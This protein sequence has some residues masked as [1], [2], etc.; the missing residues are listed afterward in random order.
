MSGINA[1][2]A[3]REIEKAVTVDVFEPGVLCASNIDR[4]GREVRRCPDALRA[5]SIWDQG[6]W[7]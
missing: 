7:F 6:R 4:K 3:A 1:T 2:N 5:L